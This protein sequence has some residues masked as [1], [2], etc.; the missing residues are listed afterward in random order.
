[1][2]I[3]DNIPFELN[4]DTLLSRL[5]LEKESK[6]TKEVRNLV[7]TV[8]PIIAPKAIYEVSY[9]QNKGYDTV[10]IGEVTF[11]SRVMRVNLDK[12]ERVFPYIA[13][14][15]KEV[16]EI[17]VSSDDFL[18]RFFLDT[19]KEMALGASIG[20]LNNHLKRKYALGKMSRMAPGA[21]APDVWPIEQQKQLFSIFGDT[22]DLIG[23]RLTDSSLMIP[24]K[25]VSGISF[26]TEIPFESC[27]LCPRER[28]PGRRAPYDEKMLETKYENQDI[29]I[30]PT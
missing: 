7:E 10:T 16:D 6:Y 2:E 15:G 8:E 23:V 30:K 11:T 27:Q 26:P 5:H 17:T 20:Y 18:R 28:C 21:S 1:M 19:I 22:E 9:I 3:L 29:G 4:F 13:T 24:N 25:S 12:V 14:C